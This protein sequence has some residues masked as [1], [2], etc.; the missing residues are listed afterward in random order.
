[1]A[2]FT[3][4]GPEQATQVISGQ[5]SAVGTSLTIPVYGMMSLLLWGSVTTSLE[6]TNGSSSATVG[7]G[8]DLAIGQTVYSP[9]G[10]VPS[11]TILAAGSG[12]SWTLGFP[13]IQ[14]T[15]ELN[16]TTT[17]SGLSRTAGLVGAAV[18]APFNPGAIPSGT[19]VSS[20]TSP[21]AAGNNGV[22]V[23]SNAA[24]I[25]GPSGPKT[26]PILLYF[27]L[28]DN[29]VVSGTDTNA[30]F[31][32]A[33]PSLT[34]QLERSFDGGNTWI[35]CN[36]G[37]VGTLSQFDTFPI[38]ASFLEPERG[39]YYRLNV[40]TYS[41]GTLNYRISVTGSVPSSWGGIAGT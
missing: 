34:V 17:V 7:S 10:Y 5:L 1:M 31:E 41:S 22:I 26:Q 16:G 12:T 33:S 13:T 23:L 14:L 37:G 18:T 32:N 25:G 29:S 28:T 11:G 24:T 30:I 36:I 3:P 15:G 38:S 40:T 27:T 4:G 20:I 19:T 2:Q 35:I 39:V 21:P 8:S 6:V 9:D